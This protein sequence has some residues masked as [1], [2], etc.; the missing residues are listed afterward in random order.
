[1]RDDRFYRYTLMVLALSCSV[2]AGFMF[3]GDTSPVAVRPKDELNEQRVTALM[4]NPNEIGGDLA[5]GLIALL[6]GVFG[7]AAKSLLAPILVWPIVCVLVTR[8]ALTGCRGAML[9]LTVGLVIL[10]Q[11]GSGV[12][13]R[14]RN[15]LIVGSAL[16]LLFWFSTQSEQVAT[17]W[18]MAL[19]NGNLAGRED[20]FPRAWDMFLERPFIGWG[21]VE[22]TYELGKRCGAETRDTHNLALWVLTQSGLLGFIPYS[23]GIWCCVKSAWRARLGPRGHLPMALV[24]TALACNISRNGE[25]SKLHWLALAIALAA[26]NSRPPCRSGTPV[27]RSRFLHPAPRELSNP[28]E[29]F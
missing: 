5:L 1:M 20:I 8:I 27:A 13:R 7:R 29:L 10:L 28:A 19:D 14:L 11:G 22:H 24:A 26:C 9:A 23:L 2:L 16:G 15:M 17:R 12:Q 6:G 18:S 25:T 21:P 3:I 4:M